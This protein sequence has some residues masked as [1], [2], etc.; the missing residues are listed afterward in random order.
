MKSKLIIGFISLI[1]ISG[2]LLCA[3]CSSIRD[4]LNDIASKSV[5]SASSGAD[6]IVN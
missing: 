3:S 6:N 2:G 5:D 1:L 4:D